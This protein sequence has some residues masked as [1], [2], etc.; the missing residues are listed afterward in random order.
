MGEAKRRVVHE[1]ANLFAKEASDKGLLIEAGWQSLKAIW[2]HPDSPAEQVDMARHAFFAGA[3]HPW[4][5]IVGILDPGEEP[6]AADLKRMD[7]IAA[8][9]DA[10]IKDFELRHVPTAGNA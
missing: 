8:E 7:L 2:L 6:T 3:Q 9:L 10:F 4:G 5:S 1:A